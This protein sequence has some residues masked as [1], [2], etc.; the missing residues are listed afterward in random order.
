MKKLLQAAL[1]GGAILAGGIVGFFAMPAFAAD[2]VTKAAPAAVGYP[3]SA[4][5]FYFGVGASA[6]AGSSSIANTGVFSTGAGLDGIVGYQW[7][8]GLDFIAAEFDATYT[9][10][11]SSGVCNVAT[12]CAVSS[13]WEFEP[14]VK[15]GFPVSYITAVLPN[16][17]TVFPALPALPATVTPVSM[18]PYIYAGAPI[19][20]L[21]AS[22]G[23]MTGSVWNVQAEA[24]LGAL[25]Q[26]PQQGVVID[27]RAGVSFGGGGINLT[28][29]TGVKGKAEQNT[30]WQVRM[31][32]LY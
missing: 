3:Y 12:Q 30:T 31:S 26:M 13:S 19:R 32:V 25:N 28:G 17:S 8:G 16:L 5:G 9:N 18:H 11:G 22:Y 23:L 6:A 7:K 2:M 20:D 15:F 4:S 27:T 21:S 29:P 24:G 14:L 10:L 1:V